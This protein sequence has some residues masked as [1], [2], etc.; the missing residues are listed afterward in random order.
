[1]IIALIALFVSIGGIGYAASKIGTSDL[2]NG[3]VT[4]RK[5]HKK[6][7]RTKKVKNKAVTTDKIRPKAVTT[8]KIAPGAVGP[9]QSNGLVTGSAKVSTTSVTEGAIGFLP[10]PVVLADV[11]TMG[12]I[13]LLF[14]GTYGQNGQIRVRVLSDDDSQPFT[15][16]A[17]M[18]AGRGPAGG[19]GGPMTKIDFTSGRF[20]AGGGEPLIAEPQPGPPGI[21]GT[22][23]T[24]DYE[25]WR[26][27]GTDVAGAHV[28]V[29]GHNSS[30]SS[31][32]A[33]QCRV[34]ATTILQG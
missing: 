29:S 4:A 1:M 24:W 31:A 28:I 10:A 25:L 15:V 6:A 19:P 21:V 20:S 3:A 16:V 2:E 23:G 5:L 22:T 9:A 8:D 11:P 7:V 26:L 32:P 30:T 12:Q 33:G 13:Q 18:I 14:C 27:D 34:R 17:R